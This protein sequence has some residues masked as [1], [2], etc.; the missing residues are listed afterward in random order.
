METLVW[1]WN[2]MPKSIIFGKLMDL[3]MPIVKTYRSDFFHDAK[4]L[5]DLPNESIVFYYTIRESGTWISKTRD[6]VDPTYRITILK[7]EDGMRTWSFEA[8]QV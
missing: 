6:T 2:H 7:S 4:W 5:Y 1:G 3:A 8:E